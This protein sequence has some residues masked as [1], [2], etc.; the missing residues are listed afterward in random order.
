MRTEVDRRNFITEAP[1]RQARR[2]ADLELADR[3]DAAQVRWLATHPVWWLR[4]LVQAEMDVN[5]H[6]E[7]SRQDLAA[8]RAAGAQGGRE[9]QARYLAAKIEGAARDQA[10]VHFKRLVE[11]RK[12]DVVSTF[13]AAIDKNTFGDVLARL[14]VA[15]QLIDDE[16]IT[17]ARDL[18]LSTAEKLGKDIR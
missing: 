6:I 9:D 10:R 8:L 12:A 2:Y 16:E 15:A 7:K 18:I 14:A 4:A 17:A 11:R 13:P 5:S 1:L 3:A